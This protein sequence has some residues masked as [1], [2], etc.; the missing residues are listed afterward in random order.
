[1]IKT[2]R[3]LCMALAAAL[4]ALS[5]AA[6][7]DNYPD[8]PITLVVPSVAGG[9]ADAVGRMVAEGLSHE[10]GK[11]VIVDNRPGAGTTLGTQSVVRAAPDGYTLLLGID[12]ALTTAPFMLDKPPYQPQKDFTPVGMLTTLQFILVASPTAPFHS[13]N[14]FIAMARQRPGAFTYASGGE[15]SVHHLAMELLEKDAGIDLRHVPY[16]AAPQGFMDVMGGH[17]D[18]MFIAPGTAVAPMRTHKVQ[19]LANSGTQAIKD[20]P[21]LPLL[22]D[23]PP[24]RGY[25]FESW[26][27]LLVRAGTPAPI[28]AKIGAALQAFMKTPEAQAQAAA[29]G[30]TPSLEGADT[31]RQRMVSDTARYAPIIAKLKQ[32]GSKP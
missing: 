8:K 23:L 1:M 9:A 12:A 25:V 15:G 27:G 21:E 7:A 14:E 10:L 11:T 3:T 13:V 30:V 22:K 20:A 2:L 5:F 18:A 28:V 6:A 32:E 26:F 17:V 4:P 16:K 29:L 24:T 31:L 19:G